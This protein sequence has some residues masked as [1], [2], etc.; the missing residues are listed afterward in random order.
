MADWSGAAGEKVKDGKESALTMSAGAK[1]IL[2][3]GKPAQNMCT[4]RK[5]SEGAFFS[6]SLQVENEGDSVVSLQVTGGNAARTENSFSLDVL[7]VTGRHCHT[8]NLVYKPMSGTKCIVSQ[9]KT[10]T[11]MEHQWFFRFVAKMH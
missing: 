8:K 2:P 10:D 9:R 7:L 11:W 6:P 3:T 1:G 4:D 5:Q